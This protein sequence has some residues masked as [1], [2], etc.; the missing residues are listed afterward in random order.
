MNPLAQFCPNVCCHASGQTGGR[1]IVI[2][3]RKQRRYKCTCCGKTFSESHG[4]SVYRLKKS[5][6]LF[7]LVVT[8]LVHGC[9]VQAIVAAFSLDARTVRNWLQRAGA[10]SQAVHAHQ[11]GQRRLDLGQVQGDEI[12]V[13]TQLGGVWLAMAVMVATRL[14]LGGV[15]SPHRDY[16]FIQHLVNQVR[17]LAW[18]RPLLFAADGYASYVRAVRSAF[19]T[20]L[21]TG[22]RGRPKLVAWA[23]VVIVQV[24]KHRHPW[25][26]QR[27]IV[28]GTEQM[29]AHLLHRTQGGG[30]INTA[31]IERLNATF[32]QRLSCL[33][34][35]TRA[36]AR[37]QQAV[38]AGMWLLGAVY[39]FCTVH[40]SL[41]VTPAMAA[42]LTDH[43]WTLD[44]LLHFKI[45][46]SYQ[47][48]KRRG[49]RP[50]IIC[51]CGFV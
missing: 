31:Y 28:Q 46:T 49:R 13:K 29:V 48:P 24:V 50:K 19:R 40:Q 38:E 33:A 23:E 16:S 1:N 22:Q 26:V 34:R 36:L 42:G 47:P 14:W 2:H 10:Q 20:P 18:E 7:T 51:S 25:S 8:L 39:N 5:S 3:S 30:H 15:V 17:H 11:L 9:P 45:P 27:R 12:K 32:R 44:E 41:A 35:R 6:E 4:T 43:R 37:T 21:R